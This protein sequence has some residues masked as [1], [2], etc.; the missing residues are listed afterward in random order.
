MTEKSVVILS[1]GLDSTTLLYDHLRRYPE[2]EVS[3]VSFD[4]GQ[5]HKKELDYA[6]HTCKVLG[7]EHDV[8]DL[9][10]M[11][12]LIGSSALTSDKEV[13]EGHYEAESMSLTVVPNRNMIML[14]IASGIAISKGASSVCTAV[15]GGD[16]YIYPDC[17]PMFMQMLDMTIRTGN[18]GSIDDRL[19][20][21]KCPYVLAS[22]AD[23]AEIAFLLGVP[24]HETWSCYKGGKVHCGRCGTCVERLEALDI[25]RNNLLRDGSALGVDLSDLTEYEDTQFWK[26]VLKTVI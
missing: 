14:A 3:A 17:R 25:A 13:P 2:V 4:Y 10:G 16:H 15:H 23:I 22:K 21:I 8:V 6:K 24:I 19:P 11:S 5:K 7:V 1:G 18:V 12:H 20:F 9:S 26:T